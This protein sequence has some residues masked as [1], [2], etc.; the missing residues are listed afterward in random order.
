VL[1][2]LTVLVEGAS[3]LSDLAQASMLQAAAAG[4]QITDAEATVND[5]RQ[6]LVALAGF[7]MLI[8][9]AVVWCV[10]KHRAHQNTAALGAR[11]Q[12]F[13]PGWAVGYYFVPVLHLWRPFQAMGEIWRASD[14]AVENVRGTEWQHGEVPGLLRGWWAAWIAA[15][16]LG[17]VAAGMAGGG[18][19][20]QRALTCTWIGIV[21][22]L[23]GI[24]AAVL[25]IVVV[26]TLTHR[27]ERA[28]ARLDHLAQGPPQ[29]L[30]Q[31]TG[32]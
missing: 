14:P 25:A 12:Q 1:L 16:I 17:N 19:S 31:T 21:G 13:S 28:Y 30:P 24:A 9:T 26:R 20:P 10:W 22:S 8:V 27:Q 3:I 7:G 32:P 29:A 15:G 6:S 18:P 4:R 23:V 5:A 2:G 11:G